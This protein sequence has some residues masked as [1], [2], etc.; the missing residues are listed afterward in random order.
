MDEHS[1]C[2]FLVYNL[3]ICIVYFK[4]QI[5]FKKFKKNSKDPLF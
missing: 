3:K 4:F 5:L 2:L 1:L